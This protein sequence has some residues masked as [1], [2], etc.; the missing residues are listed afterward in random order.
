MKLRQEISRSCARA[1]L[2]A[3][4]ATSAGV[5]LAEG[6]HGDG[7]GFRSDGFGSHPTLPVPGALIF[8]AVAVSAAAASA[9]RRR[10]AKDEAASGAQTGSQAQQ[11]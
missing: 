9:R 1:L 4:L 6:E 2:V 7:R 10:K 3:M 11:R 8:G 5:A